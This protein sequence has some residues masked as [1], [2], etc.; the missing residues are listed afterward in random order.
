MK[1]ALK[2]IAAG[3]VLFVMCLAFSSCI[4]IDEMRENVA[5]YKDTSSLEIVYQNKTYK[6][7]DIK[8][9]DDVY[10]NMEG[11]G[12]VCQSD[13][14]LLLSETLGNTAWFSTDKKLIEVS[15]YG[16]DNIFYCREDSY[17]YV[18]KTLATEDFNYKYCSYIDDSFETEYSLVDKRL[19][20]AIETVLSTQKPYEADDTAVSNMSIS[21]YNCDKDMLFYKEYV[22]IVKTEKGKYVIT[23]YDEDWNLFVYD[24]QGENLSVIKAFFDRIYK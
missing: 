13:V 23:R 4:D 18:L 2:R 20:K 24:I 3:A 8:L 6:A 10:M 5:Y 21:I 17:D 22:C 11:Y 16:E 15:G 19:E 9:D 7:I 1:R 14:P 12:A